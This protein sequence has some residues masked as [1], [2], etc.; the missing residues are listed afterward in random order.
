M[1]Y[2][3]AF[4]WT[5]ARRQLDY[6]R[7][8][9]ASNETAKEVQMF[10][11]AP[12]LIERY[13]VLADE[14]YE[15]NKKLAITRTLSGSGLSFI[16]TAGY[17]VAA[18][19][20]VLRAVAGTISIGT[21]TFLTGSFQRCRTLM[22]GL[23]SGISSIYEQTLYL[24]DL[25]EFL[26]TKPTIAS[27]TAARLVTRPVRDGFVFEDV[28]FR[29]PESERWAVRNVSFALH[30]GER[31]ALVGE[32]G[33]GK[34]TITK[35]I[36][37][38]YDPTEGRILLDGVDLREYD[39]ADLRRAIGVI[40]QDF[41]RYQMRFDENVGVGQIE[42]V[43]DYLDADPVFTPRADDANTTNGGK[44]SSRRP[45]PPAKPPQPIPGP[46]AAAAEKSLAASLL[47]RLPGGYRQMLG[48]RFGEGRGGAVGR[49][50][51]EGGPRACV[52]AG[53]RAADPRR[54]HGRARCP[55]GIRRLLAV[56][57]ADGGADGDRHL[58]SILDRP[59]GGSDRR[60]TTWRTGGAGHP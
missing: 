4:R 44:Q 9:G 22:Q 27:K 31:I 13:R 43:R 35:L 38:L 10:G 2:A 29:Y 25:F 7:Y 14:F 19:V 54:A 55:R 34:T 12:W 33:A 49:G 30:P 21:L 1:A 40:F 51:A 28:G 50:V 37:R 52:H 32:N 5:P 57:G 16:A 60:A 15:A 6:V 23:L 45:V 18:I 53:R 39:V 47:P 56:Q 46:I 59:H 48:R 26:A 24:R 8:A 11:L 42:A 17:Y 41:V 36:A 20:I 58:P 3:L